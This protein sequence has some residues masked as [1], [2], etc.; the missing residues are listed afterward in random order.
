M[1]KIKLLSTLKTPVIAGL[2]LTCLSAN[3]VFANGDF[4][5]KE[6][7]S[8]MVENIE[9]N[10]QDYQ[11]ELPEAFQDKGN[12]TQPLEYKNILTEAQVEAIFKKANENKEELQKAVDVAMQNAEKE[13]Y[14]SIAEKIVKAVE[15]NDYLERTEFDKDSV[16]GQALSNYRE[17][18][19]YQRNPNFQGT[20]QLYVF[21]S[22][23]MPEERLK[24]LDKQVKKIGGVLVIKGLVN[25]S[26]R[27]TTRRVQ[28]I[29]EEGLSMLLDPNKFEVF[30]IEQVPSFVLEGDYKYDRVVGNVSLKYAL[31]LFEGE[32]ELK[33]EAK[34]ML[35]KL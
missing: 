6:E 15:S 9:A 18:K 2:I 30:N 1:E 8:K 13:E 23:S 22:F 29:D 34:E 11:L 35:S 21:V 4:F 19:E 28:E 32:G 10:V 27:E 5:T 3:Q 20:S 17:M 33:A 31:E 25:N 14:K 24:E 26:L 7:A 12:Q 16:V